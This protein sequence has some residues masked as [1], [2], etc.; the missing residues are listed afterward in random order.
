ME[1]WY[2]DDWVAHALNEFQL[3][4]VASWSDLASRILFSLGVVVATTNMKELLRCA[5]TESSRVACDTIAVR[6]VHL[7]SSTSSL[8]DFELSAP[9][10]CGGLWVPSLRRTSHILLFLWGVV[11]LALH[12]QASVR[13]ALPQYL[14]C[15]KFGI[16][17][18]QHELEQKW[19]EFD[20]S[21]V[22]ILL[23]RDCLSLEIPGSLR[24]FSD[25]VIIKML[26]AT[27]HTW[28][29]SAAITN[30]CHPSMVWL[31]LMRVNMTEGILPAGLQS[32]DFPHKLFDIELY[33][34]NLRKL[35]DDLDSK[36][37]IGVFIYIEYNQVTAV[38]PALLRLDPTHLVLTGNPVAELQPEVF[39]VD[40]MQLLGLGRTKI[41]QL[42]RNV[43][44]FSP[45]LVSVYMTDTNISFF[46]QWIDPFVTTSLD[47]GGPVLFMAGSTYCQQ[48]D[49]YEDGTLSIVQLSGYS[50]VLTNP[51]GQNWDSI[52]HVVSYRPG[53]TAETSQI[54]IAYN[55]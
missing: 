3:I 18:K 29:A 35:P 8:L 41:L 45:T 9:T 47:L 25:V 6:P 46:W 15:E 1:K 16:R 34:T 17:G 36:W 28:G 2:D 55:G 52:L 20:R 11:V 33:F 40:G 49:E 39:E 4:L 19:D 24:D 7:K 31:Y 12:V 14:D 50:E 10:N 30:T 13:P 26:D 32:L 5:P 21:H 53:Y 48:L 43:T 37:I 23:I 42:P 22:I 54:D 38:S 44:Y 27:I 51:Y